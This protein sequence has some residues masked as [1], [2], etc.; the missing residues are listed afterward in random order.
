MVEGRELAY[1]AVMVHGG[2]GQRDGIVL[3]LFLKDICCWASGN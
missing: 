1:L 2:I 3:G